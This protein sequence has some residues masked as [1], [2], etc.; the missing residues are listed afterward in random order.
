MGRGEKECQKDGDMASQ[1]IGSRA[2]DQLD[3]HDQGNQDTKGDQD[4]RIGQGF[5]LSLSHILLLFVTPII[6][7]NL[8]GVKTPVRFVR[9]Y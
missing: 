2:N 8:T 5:G 6:N 1:G 9:I 7:E 4:G 3:G